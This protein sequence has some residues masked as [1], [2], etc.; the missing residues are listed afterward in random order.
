LF[1]RKIEGRAISA[2]PKNNAGSY[3]IENNVLAFGEQ[4]GIVVKFKDPHPFKVV[5]NTVFGFAAGDYNIGGTGI[6]NVDELEVCISSQLQLCALLTCFLQDNVTFPCAANTHSVPLVVSRMH[7]AW[8]DRWSQSEALDGKFF[9]DPEI[10]AARDVC[11]L[12]EFHVHGYPNA[13]PN[14]SSLPQQRPAYTLSRYPHPMK[15]GELI[16]FQTAVLPLL[17]ADGP[18]GIQATPIV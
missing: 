13:Y 12:K 2:D 15:I 17:G 10:M 6:C 8:F 14:Y 7:Q 18:R 1:G 4:A 11:G 16:N 5:N 9:K 3:L